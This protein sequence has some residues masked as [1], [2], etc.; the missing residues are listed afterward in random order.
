MAKQDGIDHLL[1]AL[2]HLDRRF[3]QNDWFCV[4]IGRADEPQ[5]LE[6]LAAELGISDRTWF[7]GHIPDDKMLSYLSTADI[8]AVPDPANPLNNISTMV[9]LMEYMALAKPVVAY[10]L[11]EH[12]VTAGESALY[13][14]PNS[15]VDMARQFAR[16]IKEPDLRT[17]LGAIGRERVEQHLAWH[18]HRKRFLTL[19]NDLTQWSAAHQPGKEGA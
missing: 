19:Y 4:L 6:E 1:R 12:R 11:T 17:R 9:K 7:T 16:L 3:G 8:C 5:V 18:Y 2:H 14:Q 10:D 13:A 15:E